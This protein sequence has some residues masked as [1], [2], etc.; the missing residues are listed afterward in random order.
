MSQRKMAIETHQLTKR[1]G[2]FLAVDRVTVSVPRGVVLGLLGPNGAGKTTFMRMLLGILT[3]DEGHGKVLGLDIAT[4]TNRIRRQTGYVSQRFSLYNDLTAEENL[5]F[6]GGIYGLGR[7]ELAVRRE[8]LLRWSGLAE[9]RHHL[10]AHLSGG[11]RQRL[12]FACAMVH[13]PPLMM[14]DEPTS[15]VDPISRREFWKLLYDLAEQGNTILVTTHYMDEAEHCDLLGLMLGGS[16]I[17]FDRPSALKRDL[18]VSS[19][20]EAFLTVAGHH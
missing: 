7:E 6:S 8:E 19:L 4:E 17:A 11:W 9:R 15:G 18:M 14:L 20:E 10:A 13:R 5:N 12:A 1:F 2:K 16:L 3:P